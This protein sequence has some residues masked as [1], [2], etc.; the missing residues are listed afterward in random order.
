MQ[1]Y[2]KHT[3]EFGRGLY[4]SK[5][6]KAG[7][8]ITEC[9]LLVLNEQ[10]TRIVNTTDL[11][12]YTF[13]YNETQDCLVLGQGEIFNHSDTANVDYELVDYD[14]RK[15]MQF[16]SKR[17]ILENEQLFINYTQDCKV[18]ADKYNVNLI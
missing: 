15:V 12:Y 1:Y 13:K 18:D 4:A 5:L 17:D 14:G 2:L 3:K 7:E 6:I 10:D 16:V 11:Q 8:I 9:E